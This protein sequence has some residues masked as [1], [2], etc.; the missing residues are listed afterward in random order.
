M[1]Q[2][3]GDSTGPQLGLSPP[4]APPPPWR[5]P[6]TRGWDGTL[7]QT[8]CT[9]HKRY[10]V[11][12]YI[13]QSCSGPH[14][15][16]HVGAALKNNRSYQRAVPNTGVS[17][18]ADSGLTS[19]R[20]P[21]VASL[22]MFSRS[23][24]GFRGPRNPDLPGPAPAP[25][26]PKSLN[27]LGPPG[28]TLPGPLDRL[29]PWEPDPLDPPPGLTPALPRWTRPCPGTPP[30]FGP[31]PAHRWACSP[32]RD[33]SRVQCPVECLLFFCQSD[34]LVHSAVL[35]ASRAG[36]VTRYVPLWVQNV[37]QHKSMGAA[38]LHKSMGAATQK[39]DLAGVNLK[40]DRERSRLRSRQRFGPRPPAPNFRFVTANQVWTHVISAQTPISRLPTAESLIASP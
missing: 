17:P 38:S 39:V 23:G 15:P 19:R 28:S 18:R 1:N 25:P 2:Q 8:G 9:K 16:S 27:K 13:H 5:P 6:P 31:A 4:D 33:S 26:R 30:P 20:P 3:R 14:F 21:S 34:N 10:V 7:V 12:P 35:E 32:S 22:K 40:T 37:A 24:W 11:S 29:L 36:G